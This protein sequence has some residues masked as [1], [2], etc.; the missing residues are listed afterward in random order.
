[1]KQI[2]LLDKYKYSLLVFF[3]VI[4]VARLIDNFTISDNNLGKVKGIETSKTT[5]L[6]IDQPKLIDDRLLLTESLVSLALKQ[7]IQPTTDPLYSISSE[8]KDI[9]LS[10]IHI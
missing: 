10:L 5:T 1:M 9:N 3:I 6:A 8:Y 7:P 4:L 2:F